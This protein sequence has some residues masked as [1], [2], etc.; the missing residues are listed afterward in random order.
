MYVQELFSFKV[1][2]RARD[3]LGGYVSE[4]GI[5]YK[6]TYANQIVLG[7]LRA[8]GSVGG[9]VGELCSFHMCT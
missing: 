5:F 8:R 9:H 7:V 4:L 1:L 2:F 3:S 6:C